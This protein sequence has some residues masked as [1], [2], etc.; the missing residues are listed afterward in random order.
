LAHIR[1]VDAEL[2]NGSGAPGAPPVTKGRTVVRSLARLVR[3][4]VLTAAAVAVAA[5]TVAA[6]AVDAAP[7]AAAVSGSTLERQAVKATNAAGPAI[8]ARRC[9]WTAD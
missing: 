3:P 8:R 2:T 6:G 9:G 5:A 1:A 4:A 7:A